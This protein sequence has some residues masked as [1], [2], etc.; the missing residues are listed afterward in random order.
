MCADAV[1]VHGSP[2]WPR[3]AWL[4]VYRALDHGRIETQ[5]EASTGQG[6]DF[7]DAVR[8]LFSTFRSLKHARH[9]ADYDPLHLPASLEAKNAVAQ[10]V[11]GLR[12]IE[13]LDAKHRLTLA[14]WL[15][16]GRPRSDGSKMDARAPRR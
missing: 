13:R 3:R 11:I 2:D 9:R 5:L 7:P 10:A 4:H 1:L 12:A 16:L 14:I 8:D 6:L 15:L